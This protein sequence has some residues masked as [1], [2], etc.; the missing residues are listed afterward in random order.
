MKQPVLAKPPQRLAMKRLR[1]AYESGD[2]TALAHAILYCAQFRAR[3]PAWAADAYWGG[4]I[5]VVQRTA[6]WNDLLG[7]VRVRTPK[8]IARDL[9]KMGQIGQLVKLLPT[10]RTPIERGDEAGFFRELGNKMGIKPRAVRA[11]YYLKVKFDG[12]DIRALPRWV[13]RRRATAQQ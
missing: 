1:A 2:K 3:L 11:L 4:W 13:L 10:V 6:D 9:R 7:A 12:Q 5:K 8:Q